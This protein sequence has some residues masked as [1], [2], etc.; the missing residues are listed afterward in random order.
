MFSL[1]FKPR[2]KFPKIYLE[3]LRV[4]KDNFD[5]SSSLTLTEL[6]LTPNDHGFS[7]V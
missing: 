5:L 3:R 7:G 1:K 4:G 6:T 2:E